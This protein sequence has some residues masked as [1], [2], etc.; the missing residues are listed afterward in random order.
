MS[1]RSGNAWFRS[2][3]YQRALVEYRKIDELSPIYRYAQ[4]NM[5]LAEKRLKNMRLLSAN[6]VSSNQLKD[7]PKISVIIPVYNAE[8]FLQDCVSSLR[9]QS[10]KDIEL[11][12]VDDGS[13]DSSLAILRDN[14]R[15]DKRIKIICQ[16][17]RYAG[18]ARNAGLKVASGEYIAFIDSDDFVNHDLMEKAYQKAIQTS[19][20]IIIYDACEFDTVS[21]EYNSCK[22]P[23]SRTLFPEKDVFNYLDIKDKIFQAN[24]CIPWNKLFKKELIDRSGVLFQEIKSS[25]D[26]VFVYSLLVEAESLAFLDEVLVNYRVNNLKSLQRSKSKSWA[27]IFDA[28]YALKLRLEYLGVYESVKQSFINKAFRAIVYYMDTVDQKTCVVMESSFVNKYCRLL[29]M[30]FITSDFIY[31]KSNYERFVEIKSSNYIPVVYA[32]D[33][34]Y[35][36]YTYISIKSMLSNLASDSKIVVYIMHNSSVKEDDKVRF[37]DLC[38]DRVIIEFIDMENA[39]SHIEMKISHISHVTYFRLKIHEKLGF[40]DK[41]I[42]LDSDT[43]INCDILDLYREDIGDNYIGGVRAPAFTNLK[44]QNRL[45]IDVSDYVNAGV[46]VFNVKKIIEDKVYEKFDSLISSRYACQDQDIINVACVKKIHILNKGYNF[47]T[48]YIDSASLDEYKLSS[49]KIIHFADKIKPWDDRNIPFSE[50][51]WKYASFDS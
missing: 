30:C 38:S 6:S 3:N 46:L 12:F 24:S 32:S 7:S 9:S 21:K 33:K 22:F 41:V 8:D 48:K 11:I 15:Q 28:F 25:N 36:Q 17:N 34:N 44:H 14:S 18:A 42:Y 37:S 1:L 23:L 20:E 19:A 50:L 26:T 31:L 35:L 27:C 5:A 43:I 40:Y 39:F 16:K 47:M 13:T 45:K 2:G 29:D 10:L 4:F 49:I 51:Y